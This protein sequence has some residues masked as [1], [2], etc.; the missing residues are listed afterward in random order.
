VQNVGDGNI[1]VNNSKDVNI[2]TNGKKVT[3]KRKDKKPPT[4]AATQ[5]PPSVAAVTPAQTVTPTPAITPTPTQTPAVVYLGYKNWHLIIYD[6]KVSILFIV[7]LF[8]VAVIV[9]IVYLILRKKKDKPVSSAH[10]AKGSHITQITVGGDY[11]G[12]DKV[13]KG[14]LKKDNNKSDNN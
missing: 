13:D 3:G 6:Q 7:L 14:A 10:S 8:I 5:T 1:I 4:P 11:V 12:G 9:A 2:E